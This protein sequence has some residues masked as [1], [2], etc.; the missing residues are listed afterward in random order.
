E[1]FW[2]GPLTIIVPKKAIV[3]D[4]VTA[5]LPSVGLRVPAHPMALALLRTAGIPIAA[6][7]ANR[8]TELSPTTAQHVRAGMAD[9]ILDGGPCT[10]GIESTVISLAGGA[11]RILRPGMISRTQIEEAIGPVELGAGAESPGQHPRH[12]S[13]RTPVV[14]DGKTPEGR[15]VHL[16][17]TTMPRNANAY[18]GQLYRRLHELDREGYDWISIEMPP[19][20][21][22]W[23]G[24]RDRLRRAAHRG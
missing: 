14:I 17:F 24:I 20:T 7:S 9:L 21:P 18:A 8:F 6:P 23:A 2:P 15:G 1:R 11:A 4:I 19:D 13:P 12:Y 10:V 22:E 16:D 3:P 5:G